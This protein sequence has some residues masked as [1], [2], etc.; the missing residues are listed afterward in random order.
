MLVN[1]QSVSDCSSKARFGVLWGLVSS[2]GT[3][4]G[5]VG[6][7]G[8]AYV[9]GIAA[10]LLT[11]LIPWLSP[12]ALVPSVAAVG[13]MIGVSVGIAQSFVLPWPKAALGQWIVRSLCGW[14]IGAGVGTLVATLVLV[15][16]DGGEGSLWRAVESPLL[17]V[18]M[19]PILGLVLGLTL[20]PAVPASA[21]NLVLWLA[22]NVAAASLGWIAAWPLAGSATFFGLSW[23]GLVLGPLVYAIISGIMMVWIERR[24]LT[25]S[26]SSE[27]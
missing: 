17:M 24:R 13:L 4:F 7:F 3:V 6:G 12:F 23:A 27:R 26:H 22:L 8:V 18:L 10:Y 16:L 9:V 5:I 19:T 2:L 20:R 14:G 1:T 11:T 25:A 15:Q 21:P